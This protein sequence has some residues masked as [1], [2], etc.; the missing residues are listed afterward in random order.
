MS[1]GAITVASFRHFPFLV[2][3]FPLLTFQDSSQPLIIGNSHLNSIYL[4]PIP[5]KC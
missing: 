5:I 1:Y 4:W 2:V 3:L